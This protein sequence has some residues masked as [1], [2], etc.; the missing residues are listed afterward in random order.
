MKKR[1]F[2]GFGL[3]YRFS[4]RSFTRLRAGDDGDDRVYDDKD[5]LYFMDNDIYT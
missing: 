5:N 4:V 2:V 3:L 1:I